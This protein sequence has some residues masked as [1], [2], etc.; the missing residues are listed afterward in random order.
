MEETNNTKLIHITDLIGED[1]F[2][3]CIDNG[4]EIQQQEINR[5]EYHDLKKAEN[6]H[7][8]TSLKRVMEKYRGM[9]KERRNA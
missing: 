7:Y 2:Y 8:Q 6:D 1:K 9:D 3:M 4:V 5:L